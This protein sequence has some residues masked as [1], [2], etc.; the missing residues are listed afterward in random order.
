MVGDGLLRDGSPA[1]EAD[2]EPPEP[3]PEVAA[4]PQ[5][6]APHDATPQVSP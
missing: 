1:S 3:E 2:G 5:D 4:P 6:P